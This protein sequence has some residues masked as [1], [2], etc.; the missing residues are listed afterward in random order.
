MK[1]VMHLLHIPDR[2][3]YDD[4]KKYCHVCLREVKLTKEHIPPK[5]AFNDTNQLWDRINYDNGVSVKKHEEQSGFWVRTLCK[6]CNNNLYAR[7]YVKF[8]KE[9]VLSPLIYEE[10]GKSRLFSVS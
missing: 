2:K 1:N 8:V 5:N 6:E 10:K 3:Q 9:L 7:E 4:D